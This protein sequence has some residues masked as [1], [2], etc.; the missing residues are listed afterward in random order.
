MVEAAGYSGLSDDYYD[1]N[2][3]LDAENVAAGVVFML[4]LPYKVQVSSASGDLS[5]Y[6]FPPLPSQVTELTMRPV[7]E[8][9]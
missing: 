2:P 4:S 6:S 8:K 5:F 9:V 3:A 1:A 7:G